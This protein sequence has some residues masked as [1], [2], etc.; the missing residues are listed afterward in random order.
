MMRAAP[1]RCPGACGWKCPECSPGR[2]SASEVELEEWGQQVELLGMKSPRERGDS[3][4]GLGGTG[5]R[6]RSESPLICLFPFLEEGR[7]RAVWPISLVGCGW[8][9]KQQ[10]PAGSVGSLMAH[11]PGPETPAPPSSL[12]TPYRALALLWNFPGGNSPQRPSLAPHTQYIL[13]L[14]PPP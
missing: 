11:R 8:G 10:M 13:S 14:V 6:H 12:S 1:A 5:R 2:R 9:P 3:E 4:T 7:T